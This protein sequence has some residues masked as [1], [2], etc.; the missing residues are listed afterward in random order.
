M[1]R[2]KVTSR[3]L[4]VRPVIFVR[5]NTDRPW[6][7]K[8]LTHGTKV[9]M[10]VIPTRAQLQRRLFCYLCQ[11]AMYSY[12]YEMPLNAKQQKRDLNKK[13]KAVI[14]VISIIT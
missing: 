6:M 8:R 14:G 12:R 13:Q 1:W 7:G 10:S 3:P 5:L 9:I 2:G 11:F 4:F